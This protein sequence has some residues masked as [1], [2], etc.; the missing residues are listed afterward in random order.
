MAGV[1]REICHYQK[2]RNAALDCSDAWSKSFDQYPALDWTDLMLSTIGPL[3]LAWLVAWIVHVTARWI[4]AGF[5]PQ[6]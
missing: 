2:Q 5:K 1:D 4:R 6:M 3:L